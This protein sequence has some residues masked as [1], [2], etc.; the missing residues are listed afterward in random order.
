MRVLLLGATGR[1]GAAI[2]AAFPAGAEVVAALRRP[3][4]TSRLA[5]S[6]ATVVPAV[7]DLDD[8]AGLAAAARGVDAVVNAVR[9]LGP[10][11][12][13]ALVGLHDRLVAASGGPGEAAPL[14]V[15]VGGAGSLHLPG[16]GRFW[17]HPAFPAETLPRGRAHARLRD[18]L[19]SGAAGP[20]WAYLV[21]PAAYDP[22]GPRLG[23]YD[24]TDP[25]A[26]EIAFLGRSI[27]YADFAAAVVDAVRDGWTGTRLVAAW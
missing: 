22:A 15:T 19:E 2:L 6:A 21:P 26:D 16:L 13:D 11:P 25:S 23:T 18:H 8:T 14:V 5:A 27:G 3:T 10:L 4:D 17:Q 7:V 24:T 20:R 1:S 12:A 9:L